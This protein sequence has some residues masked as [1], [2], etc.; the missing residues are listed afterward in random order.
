V[1][2]R[3]GAGLGTKRR[4][5]RRLRWIDIEYRHLEA[6]GAQACAHV[7]GTAVL[8]DDRAMHGLARRAIPHDG[9]LALIRDADAGE[10][11]RGDART[12]DRFAHGGERRV[13]QVRGVVLDPSRIREVLCERL[14][15][16]AAD[17][18]L[19]VE[20][21]GARAGGALVDGQD[22][23]VIVHDVSPSEMPRR[24]R[25]AARPDGATSP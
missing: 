22:V 4:E 11:R 24:T 9:R 1:G 23:A 7:G 8:P 25:G 20:H 19:R 3:K 15:A 5:C 18:E 13:P 14:L 10:T 17:A 16:D 2:T 21:D 6:G 12:I